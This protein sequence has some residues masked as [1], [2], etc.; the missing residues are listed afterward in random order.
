MDQNA[1]NEVLKNQLT[2]HIITYKNH[3]GPEQ[4]LTK[5]HVLPLA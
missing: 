2:M 4:L 1:L 3:R 5:M